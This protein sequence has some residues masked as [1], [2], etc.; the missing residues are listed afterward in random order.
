MRPG[1]ILVGMAYGNFKSKL[2]LPILWATLIIWILVF[3]VASFSPKAYIDWV[4]DWGALIWTIA[5]V[6]IIVVNIIAIVVNV[7]APRKRQE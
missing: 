6:L 4:F 3:S 7:I 5:M 1:G 2:G